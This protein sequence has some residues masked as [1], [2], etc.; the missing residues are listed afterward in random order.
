MKMV[1]CFSG[2]DSSRNTHSVNS[3]L[4]E[5]L[6]VFITLNKLLFFKGFYLCRA[7]HQ[8]H[9]MVFKSRNVVVA[10]I[11]MSTSPEFPSEV[12]SLARQC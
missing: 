3:Y 12:G 4:D 10:V 1:M 6:Q 11:N 9:A 8:L 5:L 2:A 7:G